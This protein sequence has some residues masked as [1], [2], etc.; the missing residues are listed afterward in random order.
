MANENKFHWEGYSCFFDDVVLAE[1]PYDTK[2]DIE[3]FKR[4]N[5][6]AGWIQA[7]RDYVSW[8]S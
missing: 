6:V 7:F 1:C 8:K 2:N 4:K 5:W 3:K